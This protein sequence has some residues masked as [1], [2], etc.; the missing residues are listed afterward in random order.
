[1]QNHLYSPAHYEQLWQA[2]KEIVPQGIV[3]RILPGLQVSD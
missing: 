3:T 1:M 2:V